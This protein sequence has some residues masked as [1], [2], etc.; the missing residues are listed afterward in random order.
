MLRKKW[1]NIYEHQELVAFKKHQQKK[2]TIYFLEVGP[3]SRV[4]P[5]DLVTPV[6][7]VV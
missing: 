2:N 7:M 4:G 5:V 1:L 6:S 3:P